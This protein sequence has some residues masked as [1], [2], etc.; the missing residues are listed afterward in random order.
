MDAVDHDD[1]VGLETV[2]FEDFTPAFTGVAE[3][4][5]GV[6]DGRPFADDDVALATPEKVPEICEELSFDRHRS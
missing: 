3:E 4:G 5:Q 1:E 6:A 2:A